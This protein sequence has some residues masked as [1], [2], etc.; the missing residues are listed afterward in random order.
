M[1]HD[2][3]EAYVRRDPSRNTILFC[4]TLNFF[5]GL[6]IDAMHPVG[7]AKPLFWHCD[8]GAVK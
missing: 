8:P 7:S 1:G 6:T 4:V 2:L 5:T 3:I